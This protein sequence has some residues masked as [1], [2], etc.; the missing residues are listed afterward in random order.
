MAYLR[1]NFKTKRIYI[2]YSHYEYFNEEFSLPAK[3]NL[4][5]VNIS[6]WKV[7]LKDLIS[8]NNNS[9]MNIG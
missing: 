4:N 6:K 8:E 2:C 9:E 1:Y 7:I 3:E 5:F